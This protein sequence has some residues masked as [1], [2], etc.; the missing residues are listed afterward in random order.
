[1]ILVLGLGYN[2]GEWKSVWAIGSRR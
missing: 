1:M 2:W